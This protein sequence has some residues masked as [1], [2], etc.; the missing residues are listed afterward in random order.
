MFQWPD[1]F[2]WQQNFQNRK[3]LK[4]VQTPKGKGQTIQVWHGLFNG[5]A[6]SKLQKFRH[7]A[8]AAWDTSVP[9]PTIELTIY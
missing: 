2:K 6:R 3:Y 1:D 9:P 5:D 8:W 7:N 4:K